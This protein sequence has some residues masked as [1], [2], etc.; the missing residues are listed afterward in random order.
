MQSRWQVIPIAW[1]V[2]WAR[3]QLLASGGGSAH[4][5]VGRSIPCGKEVPY[6]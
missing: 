5:I 1:L 3:L 6:A 2:A 4:P